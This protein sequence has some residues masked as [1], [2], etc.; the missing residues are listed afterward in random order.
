MWLPPELLTVALRYRYAIY[1][2]LQMKERASSIRNRL[3]GPLPTDVGV[4]ALAGFKQ[5]L[6]SSCSD[7]T[8]DECTNRKRNSCSF[9]TIRG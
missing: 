2:I 8:P 7:T 5:C 4:E 3:A 1:G 6:R 9:V